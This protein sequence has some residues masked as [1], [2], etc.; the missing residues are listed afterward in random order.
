MEPNQTQEVAKS[1]YDLDL[2]MELNVKT[3]NGRQDIQLQSDLNTPFA[4]I[5]F[6]L[7]N[8]SDSLNAIAKTKTQE[9][10]L[11]M[12]LKDIMAQQ[13]QEKQKEQD[14]DPV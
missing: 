6:V 11:R 12:T 2:V 3:K 5:L 13:S 9:Q 4:L 8:L 7:N 10:L 14:A 1:N